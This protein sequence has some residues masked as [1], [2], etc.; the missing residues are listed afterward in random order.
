MVRRPC[1]NVARRRW[2]S[3]PGTPP[4]HGGL[5]NKFPRCI[6]SE[7]VAFGAEIGV[8]TSSRIDPLGIEKVDIYESADGGWTAF[9][10]EA[11]AD[12][13]GNPLPFKRKPRD[14][15]KPSEINHGNVTP[16]LVR[17]ERTNEPLPGGVT[18]LFALQTT[19]VSLPALRRL[20]FPDAKGVVSPDRDTAAQVTL[21]ALALAAIVFQRERGYD[22]RSRCVLVPEEEPPFDVITTARDVES[23]SLGA[24]EAARILADAAAIA[25]QA[26]LPWPEDPVTLKPK[27]ALVQLIKKSREVVAEE[28]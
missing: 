24:D 1:S 6:S 25:K 18:M 11:K 21:A 27:P 5:G 12:P 14:R 7:I 15:G 8:R 10:G 17:G 19:V 16:D 26:G 23:F 3:A 4:A 13:K 20:R 2:S 28:E 22:L 9:K